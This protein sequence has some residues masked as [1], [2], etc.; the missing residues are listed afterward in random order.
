[1]YRPLRLLLPTQELI[2]REEEW[3]KEHRLAIA[4]LLLPL[5]SLKPLQCHKQCPSQKNSQWPWQYLQLTQQQWVLL[6]TPVSLECRFKQVPLCINEPGSSVV[7]QLH[8]VQSSTEFDFQA[9]DCEL[10]LAC[11]FERNFFV[12]LNGVVVLHEFLE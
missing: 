11:R 6:F 9:V 3:W 1:M 12:G 4:R 5:C 7:G 10:R 2:H 8:I